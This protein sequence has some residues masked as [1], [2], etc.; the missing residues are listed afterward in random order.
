M[1]IP[2]EAATIEGWLLELS[3]LKCCCVLKSC[4]ICNIILILLLVHYQ[5]LAVVS[6]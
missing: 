3:A 1:L 6:F 4:D 5:A 2:T